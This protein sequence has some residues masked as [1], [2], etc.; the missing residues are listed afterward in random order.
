[1]T[2]SQSTSPAVTCMDKYKILLLYC[3]GSSANNH[4]DDHA[5]V[6]W[7]L[8]LWLFL[9]TCLGELEEVEVSFLSFPA[10]TQLQGKWLTSG[11]FLASSPQKSLQLLSMRFIKLD[12]AQKSSGGFN[13]P[14]HIQKPLLYYTNNGLVNWFL[15]SLTYTQLPKVAS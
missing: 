9:K 15:R 1:M 2:I 12:W 14:F 5:W 11:K 13:S 7:R 10:P 6:G 4:P 3:N 8:P